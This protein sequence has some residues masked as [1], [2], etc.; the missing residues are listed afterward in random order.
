MADPRFAVGL[1]ALLVAYAATAWDRPRRRPPA[2][3]ARCDGAD[4]A[5]R[6]ATS[7]VM[8]FVATS[9]VIW[10]AAF[11]ILRYAAATEML[12]GVPVWAAA[13]GLLDPQRSGEPM[14]SG[15]WRRG[16]ALCVGAVLGV[17]AV[18]TEYPDHS[19]AGLGLVR[20]LGGTVSATPVP[21]PDGS[22]VVVGFFVSFLAPFIA[23]R[24][25][26]FVGATAWTAGGARGWTPEWRAAPAMGNHRLATETE[27]L[28]R[29]HPG[30]VFVLLETPDPTEE[31]ERF[32]LGAMQAF[33]IPFDRA[34]C[35]PVT[36]TLTPYGQICR[37]R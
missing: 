32:D 25:V 2:L 10:L 14:P 35:Q 5:A 22:L 34:S 9:Y 16:A 26:R 30:P 13:R 6:R 4:R 18:A 17:C 11:S 27:R 3:P 29:S 23:G 1:S 33:G 8:A 20:G 19:R 28:I 21:L 36:N 15:S 24:D 31:G 37:S 12:L 7:A